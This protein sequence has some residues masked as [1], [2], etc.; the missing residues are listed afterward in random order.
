[1]N[2]F[3][4]EQIDAYLEGT[5]SAAE[6][7]AFEQA[8]AQD[9]GL[10]WAVKLARLNRGCTAHHPA[11]AAFLHRLYEATVP[12]PAEAEEEAEA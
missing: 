10:F 2:H 7:G 8:V 5:M 12:P 4:F 11:Q 6:R 3:S 1:M 9:R